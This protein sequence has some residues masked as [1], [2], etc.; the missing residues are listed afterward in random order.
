MRRIALLCGVFMCALAITPL[1]FGADTEV[2]LPK[3]L[4]GEILHHVRDDA[5]ILPENLGACAY[6]LYVWEDAEEVCGDAHAQRF[7]AA[8]V[9]LM[10]EEEN[11]P[12]FGEM[13]GKIGIIRFSAFGEETHKNFMKQ[14]L[15]LL[16][17]G[18][19]ELRL[20][21]RDNDGGSVDAAL[22]ILYLFAGEHDR[23]V[24]LRY[25]T[26]TEIYDAASMKTEFLLRYRPGILRDVPTV[27]WINSGSASASEMVA[28]AMQDWGY[29]VR[30]TVSY[31]KGI[32]QDFFKLSD[33]SF[34]RLTIF[35]FFA[36]NSKKKIHGIGVHP[37]AS[38]QDEIREK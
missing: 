9:A 2:S 10:D 34:I 8:A 22:Q 26:K 20:D 3:N 11:A 37:N 13:R 1:A 25:R 14:T 35:E 7:S 12:V 16:E 28:G 30:G 38:L 17:Q 6:A 18:A 4:Y 15:M 19:E 36:G 31:K 32:G 29:A 24:T 33:G 27:V 5:L 23:F 21:L